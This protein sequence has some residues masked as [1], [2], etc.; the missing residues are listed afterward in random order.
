MPN[1]L[2]GFPCES[3]VSERPPGLFQESPSWR[4]RVWEAREPTRRGTYFPK[5][6]FVAGMEAQIW[7]L[8]DMETKE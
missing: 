2:R 1:D 6:G 8:L 7:D 3:L 4:E 5:K